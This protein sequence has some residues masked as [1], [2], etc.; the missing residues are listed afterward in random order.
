MSLGYKTCI[1]TSVNTALETCITLPTLFRFEKPMSSGE[2]ITTEKSLQ[3]IYLPMYKSSLLGDSIP[4][5]RKFAFKCLVASF[6]T[7]AVL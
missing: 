7:A 1:L 4:T 3:D 5:G 6:S 2:V